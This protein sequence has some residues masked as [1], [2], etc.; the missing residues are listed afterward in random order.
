MSDNILI[1]T[2]HEYVNE[3]LNNELLIKTRLDKENIY[4]DIN[5]KLLKQGAHEGD[6]KEIIS[7][8]YRYGG[9]DDENSI[10]YKSAL[11][12]AVTNSSLV[13]KEGRKPEDIAA[14]AE[15]IAADIT[16]RAKVYSTI[17]TFNDKIDESTKKIND[18]VNEGSA[19][20]ITKNQLIAAFLKKEPKEPKKPKD[21]LG[22]M[23]KEIEGARGQKILNINI[24]KMNEAG[25][26]QIQMN[27]GSEEA[28]NDIETVFDNLWA[29]IGANVAFWQ[30]GSLKNNKK[31]G[32]L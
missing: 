28:S 9:S 8:A 27:G 24:E 5:K 15:Q 11:I 13:K 7:N 18:I 30:L 29:K 17:N 3:R 14:D 31:Y 22:N 20:G 23:A 21:D 10:K 1:K 16:Q 4:N 6:I 12:S 25:G 32:K 2:S 26:I 19:Y